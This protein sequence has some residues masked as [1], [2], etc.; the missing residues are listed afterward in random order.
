MTRIRRQPHTGQLGK[1]NTDIM[2][3]YPPYR[4]IFIQAGELQDPKVKGL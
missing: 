1:I 2:A 4:G 3:I